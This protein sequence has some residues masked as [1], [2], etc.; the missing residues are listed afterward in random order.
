MTTACATHRN[1]DDPIPTHVA[2]PRRRREQHQQTDD[3][4]AAVDAHCQQVADVFSALA[5]QYETD[6]P[7]LTMGGSIFPDRVVTHMST[8]TTVPKTR[9][10]VRSGCYITHDHG[11]Y[12]RTSPIAGLVPAVSVRAIV[13][14]TP[15]PGVAV[16]G[17]GRRELPDDAG[18]PVVLAAASAGHTF[19][20]PLTKDPGVSDASSSVTRWPRDQRLEPPVASAS[21]H[22]QQPDRFRLT[23]G[24]WDA[25]AEAGAC[26]DASTAASTCR[27]VVGKTGTELSAAEISSSISV[28]PSTTPSAPARTRRVMT[29][30]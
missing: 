14:S 12:A 15:E 29:S 6:A 27:R 10:I 13:L 21:D 1:R 16:V 19:C 4:L 25:Q 11:I 8:V 20:T 26:R 24:Q 5:G 3:T 23:I 22:P 7:I 2:G 30:R 9:S 17:A 28:Q 18:M